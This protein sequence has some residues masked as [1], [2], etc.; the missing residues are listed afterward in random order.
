LFLVLGTWCKKINQG[1]Q[2]VKKIRVLVKKKLISGCAPAPPHTIAALPLRSGVGSGIKWF[3][4][5]NTFNVV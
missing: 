5:F 3:I 2:K 4:N 1:V